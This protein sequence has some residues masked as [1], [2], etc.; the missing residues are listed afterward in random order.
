MGHFESKHLDRLQARR[1]RCRA[2]CRIGQA[3]ERLAIACRAQGLSAELPRLSRA[4]SCLPAVGA[5]HSA[6]TR[7][8]TVLPSRKP[9]TF[10]TSFGILLSEAAY[11]AARSAIWSG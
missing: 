1:P 7:S 6:R 11:G 3:R 2:P 10:G 8:A 9:R 5:N 4:T